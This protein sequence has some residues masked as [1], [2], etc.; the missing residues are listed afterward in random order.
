MLMKYVLAI[1]RCDTLRPPSILFRPFTISVRDTQYHKQCSRIVVP[2]SHDKVTQND[3][4]ERW[5]C[6]SCHFVHQMVMICG[7]HI[8]TSVCAH[9]PCIVKR[10]RLWYACSFFLFFFN[11]STP[12]CHSTARGTMYVWHGHEELLNFVRISLFFYFFFFFFSFVRFFLHLV[13]LYNHMQFQSI[14]TFE[15]Y[16]QIA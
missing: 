5:R 6:Q 16:I 10:P 7:Y 9:S 12:L 3:Q 14:S 4:N 8:P 2:P 1:S 13:G 15:N 11:G